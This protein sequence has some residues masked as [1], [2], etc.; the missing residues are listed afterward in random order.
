MNR[1]A[2]ITKKWLRSVEASSALIDWC[3]QQPKR[4]TAGKLVEQLLS[5]GRIEWANWLLSRILARPQVVQYAIFAAEQVIG[6]YEAQYP[7]DS[8]PR[9][10]IAAAR[11]VLDDDSADN[12]DAAERAAYETGCASERAAGTTAWPARAAACAASAAQRA[13]ETATGIEAGI[14]RGVARSA[15]RA[16]E[17]AAES[18]A[19]TAEG[20]AAWGAAWSAARSAACTAMCFRLIGY[21]LTLMKG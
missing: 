9:A 14:V 12:R 8:R 10:A 15:E 6:I 3:T 2:R 17:N 19:W 7:D 4:K 11:R 21:G 13:A 1:S 18:A 16:V 20:S 5:E